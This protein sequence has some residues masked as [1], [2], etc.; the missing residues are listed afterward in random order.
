MLA[1]RLTQA[2]VGLKFADKC[3]KPRRVRPL[4]QAAY[5]TQS[6]AELVPRSTHT[7]CVELTYYVVAD[8]L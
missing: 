2:E 1:S 8:S 7:A 6:S 3:V 5:S 4:P